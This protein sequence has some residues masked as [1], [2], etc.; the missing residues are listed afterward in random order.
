MDAVLLHKTI[1]LLGTNK[2]DS[3]RWSMDRMCDYKPSD[4]C[5][6]FTTASNAC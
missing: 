2:V 3:S 6:S 4:D 1:V 5:I